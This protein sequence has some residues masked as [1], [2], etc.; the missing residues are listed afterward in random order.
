MGARKIDFLHIHG[1][2]YIYHMTHID[3]VPGILKHGLQAHGNSY[4]KTDISNQDVNSRRS[5][6]EP[7]YGKRIHDY[8]PFYFSPRN[9]MLYAQHNEDDIVILKLDASLMYENGMIFTDGNASS[10]DTNFYRDFCD[11]ERLNWNCI[12]AKYWN[13]YVDGRRMKMA[14]VLLPKKVKKSNISAILCK[15]NDTRRKVNAMTK[16]KIDCFVNQKFYF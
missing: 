12:H 3:N 10:G 6:R 7:V 15:N 4:Q 13:D 9:A 2:E 8:V 11:L 14:E 1:V 16:K 5:R